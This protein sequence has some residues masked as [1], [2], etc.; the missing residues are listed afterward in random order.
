[1]EAYQRGKS[2]AIAVITE[3][4]KY[5]ASDVA[6]YFQK[7]HDRIGIDLRLTSLGHVQ[8]GAAPGA[9]D[10][11]LAT[12]FGATA[13]NRLVRKKPGCLVGFLKGDVVEIPL[14]EVARARKPL[15]LSLME[16]AKILA[17]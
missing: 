10:R 16:L 7:N 17:R 13:V 8:R 5:K 4:T 14:E 15:D 9:F 12:R 1:M 2:H 3:G 11:L 6:T